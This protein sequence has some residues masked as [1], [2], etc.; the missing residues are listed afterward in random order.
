MASMRGIRI[1]LIG[2]GAIGGVVID[3]LLNGADAAAQDIVACEPR[4]ARRDELAAR[5]KIRTTNNP[6]EAAAGELIVLAL[7]PLEV[8]KTLQAIHGNLSHRPVIA[9]FAA[10]VPISSLESM[11]PPGTPVVRIN[12]N[13]PSVVGTGFNPV[14]YGSSVTG[15][16]RSVVDQFLAV[17]GGT[18][19][20]EDAA[21]NAYTALSAVGPTYFLPVLDAMIGA[22]MELGLSREAAVAAATETA[23]G[24]A[25]MAAKR[26][27]SPEQLKLF[28]GLRPL[29][30]A[31]VRDLVKQ[32]IADAVGRM[33]A[34]QQKITAGP[35]Q[36]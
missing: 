26:P 1:G 12:P 3:R 28:T 36:A 8:A 2:A 14:T 18:V 16:A 20:I 34:L 31:E 6:V 30:D 9:S 35:S 15:K 27:E 19:E 5:F 4:D 10:A 7:P 25:A 17:L 13:S 33:T 32:A 24:T 21:M 23:R 11:L 29:K 22:G